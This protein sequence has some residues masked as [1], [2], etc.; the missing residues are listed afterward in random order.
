[1]TAQPDEEW[2]TLGVNSKQQ[3]AELERIHQRNVADELLVAGVTIADPA[4]IDVRG[5]LECG[6]DVSI[7]VNCVFEGKVT[8]ADNVS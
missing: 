2:E 3:L 5:T 6:R 7:D 4:R 8:L 1:V